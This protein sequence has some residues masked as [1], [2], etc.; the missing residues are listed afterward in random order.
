MKIALDGL[1]DRYLNRRVSPFFTRLFLW[2][3][4]SPNAITMLSLAIG[5]MAAAVFAVGSYAAGVLGGILLQF[6]AIID[7][8]DGEV[9]RLTRTESEFGKQLDIVSDNIVHIAVFAGVAWAVYLRESA[10]GPLALGAAAVLG[11]L[12]SFFVLTR[13]RV[14]RLRQE[15]AR[16]QMAR[17]E[18]MLG[19]VSRDFSLLLL[20][21]A[22]LDRLDWFLW[23]AAVGA[24]LFWI[25]MAWISRSPTAARA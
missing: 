20:A 8:C 1:V 3:G 17:V 10:F 15:A 19:F 2:M 18:F 6:S 14:L 23:L 13:L 4:L 24:N 21:C 16:D 9:A 22:V 7:C 5:L 12:A 25:A 11:N